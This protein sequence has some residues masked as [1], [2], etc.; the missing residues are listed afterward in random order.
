MNTDLPFAATPLDDDEMGGL[1]PSLATRAELNEFEESNILSATLWASS[2]RLLRRDYPN[3][4]ALRRLHGEMFK[5]TWKWAGQFRTSDKNIGIHWP[6]V[7]SELH[8]LCEDARYWVDN[9]TYT[10]VELGAR[11]HQRLVFIHPFP[12]GNGRHG[13]LATDIL[14]RQN[15]QKS[16]T[17]GSQALTPDGSP[18]KAYIAALHSA[19]VGNLEPLIAFVQT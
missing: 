8:K 3:V 17:W 13:R 16:F 11:F 19:D 14:L 15:G 7:Q 9:Q 2:S 10:W 4:T 1:I 6:Q 18:R 5:H 12:N